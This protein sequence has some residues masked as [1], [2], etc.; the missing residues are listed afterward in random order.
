M[1][2]KIKLKFISLLISQLYC[3]VISVKQAKKIMVLIE[4]GKNLSLIVKLLKT[5]LRRKP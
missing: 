5:I 1:T 3:D 2:N 4:S